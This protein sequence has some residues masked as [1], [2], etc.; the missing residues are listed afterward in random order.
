ML[1][2]QLEKP[3]QLVLL[4][5]PQALILEYRGPRLRHARQFP[6]LVIHEARINT[7]ELYVLVGSKF[8][9]QIQ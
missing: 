5:Q 4:R 9:Y 6:I 7:L 8:Q 1:L 2:N 3:H